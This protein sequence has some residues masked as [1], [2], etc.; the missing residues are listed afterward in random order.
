MGIKLNISAN[1]DG[2]LQIAAS[3]HGK[4]DYSYN[5]NSAIDGQAITEC[6]RNYWMIRI[7]YALLAS[8]IIDA[9]LD[10]AGSNERPLGP[11]M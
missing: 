1:A 9:E 8:F 5:I 4:C 2:Y 6:Q 7:F 11:I 3:C 10:S